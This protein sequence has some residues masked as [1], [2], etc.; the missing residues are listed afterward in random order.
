MSLPPRRAATG[1]AEVERCGPAEKGL[2]PRRD[3]PTGVPACPRATPVVPSPA[4]CGGG[5][6]LSI[7]AA[8]SVG[9]SERAS[10]RALA[11][12]SRIGAGEVAGV[13]LA[14]GPRC[15]T[16]WP[17]IELRRDRVRRLTRL[18]EATSRS[19]EIR[20]RSRTCRAPPALARRGASRPVG[21]RLPNPYTL[22]AR[23]CSCAR[24]R[25]RTSTSCA[26]CERPRGVARKGRQSRGGAGSSPG[27]RGGLV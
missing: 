2:G 5:G 9:A 11:L 24:C 10:A 6:V 17:R 7:D 23:R 25:A 27:A 14:E 18:G 21:V 3:T 4:R 1:V 20:R 8:A 16:A 13:E 15:R 26:R 12:A 19:D 22:A